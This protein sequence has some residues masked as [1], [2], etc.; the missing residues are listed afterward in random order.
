MSRPGAG[1]PAISRNGLSRASSSNPIRIACVSS[2]WSSGNPGAKPTSSYPNSAS[3]AEAGTT[4]SARSQCGAADAPAR[5]APPWTNPLREMLCQPATRQDYTRNL[6]QFFL[7]GGLLAENNIRAGL[8]RISPATMR[9]S[10]LGSIIH[11][12]TKSRFGLAPLRCRQH[13]AQ[14]SSRR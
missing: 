4:S 6:K 12:A 2:S 8:T 3:G 9:L 5:S 14:V 1:L 11:P 10:S 13:L 7:P